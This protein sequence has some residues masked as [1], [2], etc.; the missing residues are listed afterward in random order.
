MPALVVL[1][2]DVANDMALAF[3][4]ALPNAAIVLYADTTAAP[5][6]AEDDVPAGALE[7]LRVVLPPADAA[8]VVAGL[9]TVNA[10]PPSPWLATARVG[11]ARVARADGTGILV[12][13]VGTVDEALV[14]S[15]MDAVA[16]VMASVVDWR[17]HVPTL[18]GD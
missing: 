5:A 15:S 18:A 16:G 2:I 12:P 9:V 17:F 8:T 7:L 3:A 10:L 14:V 4:A 11:W 6:T 1:A 13:N